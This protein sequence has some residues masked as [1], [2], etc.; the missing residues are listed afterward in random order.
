MRINVVNPKYLT[1][2]HL[3]A[4]YREIKMIT[5]Y[6]VKSNNT[7]G[8]IDKSRISERYTLNKGHGYMWYDKFNYVDSRFKKLC[9]E[10]RNRGFACNYD[11]LNYNGIPEEAFGDFIPIQEDIR[12]NLD[13]I[14]IRIAK[15]PHW[16]KYYGERISD[17]NG[18]YEE[19][20]K[21]GDLL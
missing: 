12:I 15:Q 20:F 14:K 19:L 2:N 21:E 9:E 10:M 13:R 18:F 4:E 5:Y 11:T 3:I 1:D 16:Y 8:G 17:W 6:Y 7:A